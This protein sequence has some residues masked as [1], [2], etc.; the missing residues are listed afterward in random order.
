MG[1]VRTV[2]SPSRATSGFSKRKLREEP[3][4]RYPSRSSSRARRNS[5]AFGSC[6]RL[7]LAGGAVPSPSGPD[8]G[9]SV[10]RFPNPNARRQP[11]PGSSARRPPRP[12]AGRI[13]ERAAPFG[14]YHP[15]PG[16]S[17]SLQAHERAGRSGAGP[18]R[19]KWPRE[20]SRLSPRAL[21]LRAAS[22][23][24]RRRSHRWP[25]PPFASASIREL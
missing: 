14:G 13:I 20:P 2:V 1:T 3:G 12:F 11:I 25:E 9:P 18:N 15:A 7:V 10:P 23:Q 16:E 17:S 6:P 24:R 5:P 19:S 8:G 22:R 4:L 21:T